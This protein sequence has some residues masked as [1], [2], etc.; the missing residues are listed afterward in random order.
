[1]DESGQTSEA[2]AR[3]IAKGALRQEGCS[4]TVAVPNTGL[5]DAPPAGDGPAAGSQCLASSFRA[6]IEHYFNELPRVRRTL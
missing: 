1:M 5:A 2:V 4:A 3:E 6:R